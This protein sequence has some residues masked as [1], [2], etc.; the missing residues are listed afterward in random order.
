MAGP[1]HRKAVALL[2]ANKQKAS[3]L[4]R[5]GAAAEA[6]LGAAAWHSAQGD[7]CETTTGKLNSGTGPKC[8]AA[9]QR[10]LEPRQPAQQRKSQVYAGRDTT[11]QAKGVEGCPSSSGLSHEELVAQARAGKQELSIRGEYGCCKASWLTCEHAPCLA[12]C[13]PFIGITIAGTAYILE[14]AWFLAD[15]TRL[16]H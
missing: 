11:S 8:L 5:H 1:V 7:A 3:R 2:E 13:K 14:I 15:W 16:F 9:Q 4:A 6:A 12:Y 10:C